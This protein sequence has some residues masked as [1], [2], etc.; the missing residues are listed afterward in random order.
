MKNEGVACFVISSLSRASYDSPTTMGSFK[1]SGNIEFAAD[2]AMALDYEAMYTSLKKNGKVEID[3]NNEK[4]KETRKV[5]LTILK[6]RIGQAGKQISYDF[7]PAANLF[8]E[9][10]VFDILNCDK[11]FCSI[12]CTILCPSARTRGKEINVFRKLVNRI[13]VWI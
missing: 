12:I 8:A 4:S 7:I 13:I 10:G 6:N 2:V 11:P 3:M 1:E 9:I 5:V